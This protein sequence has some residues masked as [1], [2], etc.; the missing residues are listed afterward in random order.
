MLLATL[1]IQKKQLK[2]STMRMESDGL[3]LETLEGWNQMEAFELLVMWIC[4]MHIVHFNRRRML[5]K[6]FEFIRTLISKLVYNVFM[7]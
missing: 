2:I 6:E 3:R 7:Q 1:R 5:P 4:V